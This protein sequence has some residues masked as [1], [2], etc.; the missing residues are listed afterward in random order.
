[1]S[2]QA[3][4]VTTVFV[5]ST[6]EDLKEYREACRRVI[7][8]MGK[9]W[10]VQ[11]LGMEI[12]G[13]DHPPPKTASLEMVEKS[14]I[15][16]GIFGMRYGSIDSQTGK[17]ITELEYRKAKELRL[18]CLI[19]VIDDD[20]PVKAR[21]VETGLAAD[22]LRDLKRELT[23]LAQGHTV[24]RFHSP[25][26]LA[27]ELALC[28]ARDLKK[29]TSGE[30]LSGLRRRIEQAIADG[31]HFIREME[32]LPT[33]G[34][35]FFEVGQAT[36]WDTANSLLALA[37]GGQ[38]DSGA[39]LHRGH[40]WLIGHRNRSGGWRSPWEQNLDV[41]TTIDTAVAL[42]ALKET[43]YEER[44]WELDSTARNLLQ[45]QIPDGGWPDAFGQS[46]PAT[47]ATAWA[48]R[49]LTAM[50][51]PTTDPHA[52]RAQ[53]WLLSQQWKDGG[54]AAAP[55][56]PCS[57]VG[58]TCDAL[59]GIS[60]FGLKRTQEAVQQAQG[61][62]LRARRPSASA[63]EFGRS[64]GAEPQ[65]VNPTIENVLLFLEAAFYAGI[66]ASHA[67]VK[68]DLEW[69]VGRRWWAYTPRAVRCLCL[70]RKWIT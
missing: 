49:A 28:I 69:I 65:G 7:E 14:D 15:Y 4:K 62:L 21:C 32:I 64:V 30:P 40:H 60:S 44:P 70:Y 24:Y 50:G 53:D 52:E 36:C 16:V 39:S 43:G 25:D 33:G 17:S 10:G 46:W 26:D 35:S 27:R 9:G 38:A 18:P 11:F 45:T 29:K 37:A 63:E 20:A 6:Y 47:G 42:L 13:P 8:S 56:A 31:C 2:Q 66:P 58:K 55:G 68:D 57:T 54:W 1:M 19:F 61:W 41:S 59:M 22:K 48:I 5:S 51:F 67:L 23:D 34:W 3:E 12:I